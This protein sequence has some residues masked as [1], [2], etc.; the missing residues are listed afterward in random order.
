MMMNIA[1]YVSCKQVHHQPL[2]NFREGL[3][4]DPFMPRRRK[5]KVVIV[6]GATGT[7]KSRLSI[8]LANHFQ[9]EVVNSDKMQVYK[10]LDIVTNKVTEE[11][12]C[13]I[14]HHLLGIADP[15]E[16]FTSTDFVH[17][18][19]MAVG[20]ITRKGH[21]PIIAGGSNSYI[22]A[23]VNDDIEFKS[24]YECCFLWIDVDLAVLRRF[25]SERVDKMV[26]EGLV[27]E[28]REFFNPEGDYTN[29]IRR[30]IGVPELDQ[31]FRNENNKLIDED[32]RN[33]ILQVAIEKIKANT[34][35]LATCQRQNILRLESQLGWNISRL[36]AT[37]AFEKKG[38]EGHQ[39]WHRL[40][41]VPSTRFVRH[42]RR[43]ELFNIPSPSFLPASSSI[44]I[45]TTKPPAILSTF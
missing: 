6:M 36:D 26:N 22:K 37:E 23:L 29:G 5:D 44:N 12:T 38:G 30:A 32:A 45:E 35:K 3:T 11:E 9:A 4:I 25:V 41:S 21:L 17:H 40:V 27:E 33:R 16:N 31:Y 15:N 1:S 24:R 43:E 7:G 34:C 28:V 39:A 8:D 13:G 18:A 10:G 2:I 20:S 14:Q 19:S 42:F